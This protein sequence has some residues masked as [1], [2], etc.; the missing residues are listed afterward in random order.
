MRERLVKGFRGKELIGFWMFI[1]EEEG[2]KW[3]E[4]K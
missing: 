3:E 2:W 1:V 4:G